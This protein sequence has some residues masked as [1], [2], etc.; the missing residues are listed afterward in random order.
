MFKKAVVVS[1]VGSALAA[2]AAV[3]P[4]ISFNGGINW[5]QDA[6]VGHS[7]VKNGKVKEKSGRI[8]YDSGYAVDAAIGLDF[9]SVP[10]RTELELSYQENDV[11]AVDGDDEVL[12]AASANDTQRTTA[13]MWNGYLDIATSSNFKPF[14][15]AGLG[16][17]DV[18]MGDSNTR[19]AYQLG[20]GFGYKI[21]DQ[22]FLDVRYKF[23]MTD[24]FHYNK[25]GKQ[26]RIDDIS[27][28]QLQMGLRYRF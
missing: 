28:H 22:L 15:L 16:G 10:L 18:D 23:F 5:M 21:L 7:Y 2:Q 25:D 12:G 9:S 6:R 19:F 1:L 14:I 24:P 17:V 27:T 11:S 13:L 26:Y 8:K 3:S 20:A 4:Y